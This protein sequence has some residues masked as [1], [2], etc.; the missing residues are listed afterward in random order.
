[1]VC[2]YCGSKTQVVNSRALKRNNGVWRR[3][4]C[5][6]CGAIM[7]TEE[8]IIEERTLRVESSGHLEPFLRDKLFLSVHDSVLHRKSALMDATGLTDTIVS[9]VYTNASNGVINLNDIKRLVVTVLKRFDK[10]AMVHY[11]AHHP[12]D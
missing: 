9:F 5:L 4:K 3:R 2:I 8:A 12:I 11:Q 7:S 1:M 10:S 6:S